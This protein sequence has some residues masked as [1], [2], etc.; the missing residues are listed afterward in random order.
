[1]EGGGRRGGVGSKKFDDFDGLPCSL[2][3][4]SEGAVCARF[5]GWVESNSLSAL[6]LLRRVAHTTSSIITTITNDPDNIRTAEVK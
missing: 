6:P 5:P 2:G 4:T 3:A 1:M